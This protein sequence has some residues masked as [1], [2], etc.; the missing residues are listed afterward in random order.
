MRLSG[1]N[2]AVEINVPTQDALMVEVAARFAAQDG[3]ALATINLDHVTKLESDV[4]FRTAYNAQDLVVAD[5]NPIV[6]VSRLAGKSVELMPGSEL[7]VPLTQLAAEKGVSIALIGSS[8]ASL[9]AAAD[10][11]KAAA[12][13]LEISYVH[14]PEYG[15]DPQ[16]DAARAVLKDVAASGAQ[17]AF[18]ALG[19]PKQELFAA[20][21]RELAPNVGFASIG[22]GLDFLSGE[23]V[24][25]PLWVRKIAMEWA[26]RLLSNPRRFFMRYL[27][28]ALV[29]PGLGWRAFK[30]R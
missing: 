11:L 27:S 4:G 28:C 6:W 10:A 1:K 15:F 19:A 12:Q 8:D 23:Q 5:G 9:A 7:V 29:L 20:L 18:L 17:L 2:F 14:A 24:R 3:F 22:A 26:W 21:G 25:A 30:S 16:G 13:G